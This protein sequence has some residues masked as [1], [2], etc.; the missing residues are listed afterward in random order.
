M[1]IY[2][3]GII[4]DMTAKE[5]AAMQESQ[6][7]AE[8]RI[9][10]LTDGEK[11][12]LMLAAIPEEPVPTTEPK[13]GYKW[14]PMYSST[15]GFAWE[16]VEDPNVLGT[17]KNPLQWISGMSVKMGYHYTVDGKIYLALEDGTPEAI[18][19]ETYFAEL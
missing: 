18:T 11:I 9:E 10:P 12:A 19:D 7:N 5:I 4:R 16:L 6:L 3:N 2:I 14:Q 8:H 17:Q 1:K 15:A 13:V